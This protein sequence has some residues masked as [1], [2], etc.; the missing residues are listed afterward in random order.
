[1]I[2]CPHCGADRRTVAPVAACPACGA[3]VDVDRLVTG[4]QP[5]ASPPR[6]AVTTA[7][8]EVS[9]DDVAVPAGRRRLLIA[10]GG[11]AVAMGVL[12][13]VILSS[14]SRG[15]GGGSSRGAAGAAAT[16]VPT[17]P[18]PPQ[19]PKRIVLRVERVQVAA[20]GREWDGPV[21]EVSYKNMCSAVAGLVKAVGER[22]S[23][24]I[25]AKAAIA[26]VACD[27]I[28]DGKQRQADP[29]EPDLRVELRSG[30]V[31]YTSYAAPDRRA[32]QFGYSF[33]IPDE[34]IPA[35]GLV[36]AVLD[37]DDGTLG[38]EEI[39][40]VRLSRDQ[41][42]TMAKT[43]ELASL[44]AESL[45]LLE[46]S[47]TPHDGR[48][49]K[50]EYDLA[51]NSG[52]ETVH[53]IAVNAGEVVRIDA[54]GEWTIGT[55]TSGNEPVHP[56]GLTAARLQRNNLP[57]FPGVA[58]GSTVALVGQQGKLVR[59]P[60]TPCARVVSPFAGVVWVGIN[61]RAYGDN[62]GSAHIRVFTRA[63]KAAEWGSP[64]ALL[65]CD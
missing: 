63:P 55:G 32:H 18:P 27:F 8:V 62:R 35:Q 23:P 25:G 9:E 48:L 16:A 13:V 39:G 14:G 42:I 30:P 56:E 17:E 51:T 1:M 11:V 46:V 10:G 29:R 40:S 45:S 21:A 38:G 12:L 6:P 53:G 49:R 34:S 65:G 33:V 4:A 28:G 43:G 37:D 19:M 57:L 41:L 64:G 5:L 60:L 26:G 61:D 36:V 3:T 54:S 20:G 15:G 52:G 59:L 47:V 2:F 7:R 24:M 58:H 31:V 50:V 44:S 22:V